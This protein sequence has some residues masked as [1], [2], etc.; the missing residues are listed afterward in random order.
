M[1]SEGGATI[2]EKNN[3]GDTALI[4]AAC[5]GH[6]E[7]VQW[8]LTEGGAT[9]TEKNKDGDTALL[10]ATSHGHLDVVRW[11]LIN[12][13]DIKIKEQ[14]KVGHSALLYIVQGDYFELL[15]LILEQKRL[16]YYDLL[17]F[18]QS[19][20][21]HYSNKSMKLITDC[22]NSIEAFV[23]EQHLKVPQLYLCPISKKYMLDPVTGPDK[24]TYERKAIEK[25]LKVHQI[26]PFTGRDMQIAQLNPSLF[27]KEIIA[28]HLAE[29]NRLYLEETMKNKPASSAAGTNNFFKSCCDDPLDSQAK[30][31]KK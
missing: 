20:D 24:I 1:L 17:L 31:F 14:N 7:T 19:I 15:G 25:W 23:E 28:E 21:N 13:T 12:Q 9:I 30:R 18:S 8:L 10:L 2:T 3:N 11:L 27:V 29:I 26:S 6:L 22:I 4:I 5:K 16:S